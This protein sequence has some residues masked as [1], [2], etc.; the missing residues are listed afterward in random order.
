[1]T[2]WQSVSL[3]F[4]SPT[5]SHHKKK[6]FLN[7]Q[8]W[9]QPDVSCQVSFPTH[10]MTWIRTL[11]LSNPLD[12]LGQHIIRPK[13]V[14]FSG[15]RWN[16]PTY[17]ALVFK[18]IKKKSSVF[19]I[20]FDYLGKVVL[21]VTSDLTSPDVRLTSGL[22]SPDEVDEVAGSITRLRFVWFTSNFV[23]LPPLKLFGRR[24]CHA[25][26]FLQFLSQNVIWRKT[27]QN[28]PGNDVW[29]FTRSRHTEVSHNSTW[30]TDRSGTT[31]QNNF[32]DRPCQETL[33]WSGQRVS[34]VYLLIQRLEVQDF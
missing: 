15:F 19:L 32:Y 24:V 26:Q 6:N 10:L 27:W 8:T 9:R 13:S 18:K 12:C 23:D 33:W 28:P 22:R 14:H 4:V 2:D 1:M 30:V 7:G 29:E 31:P 3:S 20:I 25:S 11:L 16:R 34:Q 21:V 17:Q 5:D